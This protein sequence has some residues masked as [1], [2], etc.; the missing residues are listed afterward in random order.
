MR[1]K[2]AVKFLDH[3][4][5]LLFNKFQRKINLKLSSKTKGTTCPSQTSMYLT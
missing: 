2:N 3:T 5:C 4:R 1:A